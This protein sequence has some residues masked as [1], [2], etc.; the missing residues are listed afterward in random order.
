MPTSSP[1]TK[2]IPRK[3]PE[4]AAV[5]TSVKRAMRMTPV[6]NRL[7]YDDTDATRAPRPLRG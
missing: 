5:V 6:L 4:S 7:T 2:I 1:D 3:T